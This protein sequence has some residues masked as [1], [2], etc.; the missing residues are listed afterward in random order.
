MQSHLTDF[1]Q[2]E[3][4]DIPRPKDLLVLR[5]RGPNRYRLTSDGINAKRVMTNFRLNEKINEALK[6][7]SE[8]RGVSMCAYLETLFSMHYH[9]PE[10]RAKLDDLFEQAL[11]EG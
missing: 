2:S 8:S 10:S 5:T 1:A 6:Q 11:L 4:I 3:L 9:S 7:E